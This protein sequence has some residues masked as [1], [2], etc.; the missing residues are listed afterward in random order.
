MRLNVLSAVLGVGLG[1]GNAGVELL[2]R[3][4]ELRVGAGRSWQVGRFLLGA[5][6]E[7]GG[8]LARQEHLPD[9]SIRHG[10]A[11]YLGLNGSALVNLGGPWALRASVG[12]GPLVVRKEA[13]VGSDAQASRVAGDFL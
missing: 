10:L 6:L 11:P 12:G 8:I 3:E 5:A 4:L 7:G 13:G 1:R 9:G 2:E